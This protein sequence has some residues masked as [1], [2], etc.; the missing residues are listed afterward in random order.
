MNWWVSES[1]YQFVVILNLSIHSFNKWARL[2]NLLIIL[3]IL[4]SNDAMLCQWLLWS[5]FKSVFFNYFTNVSKTI[6]ARFN[7]WFV[8][9]PSSAKDT[10]ISSLSAKLYLLFYVSCHPCNH[11]SLVTCIWNLYFIYIFVSLSYCVPV[12]P[13]E[14]RHTL[15]LFINWS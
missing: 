6:C 13:K 2:S 1:C 8:S 5:A 9:G 7:N 15:D 14:L 10:Y 12:E 3:F 11:D 4:I